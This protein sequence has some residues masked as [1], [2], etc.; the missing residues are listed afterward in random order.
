MHFDYRKITE[1]PYNFSAY[2]IIE[3]SLVLC[4]AHMISRDQDKT[5]FSVNNYID[6]DWLNQ[7]YDFD[8]IEKG[9]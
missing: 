5:V 7:L 8:W 2:W 1:N 9:I 4:N 3:I 6:W